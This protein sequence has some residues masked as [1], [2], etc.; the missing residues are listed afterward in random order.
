MD[1]HFRAFSFVDRISSI[2]AG[3][4]VAGHYVIPATLADFSNSLVSEAVGQL[5][6][7]GAMSAVDFTHRPVAGLAGRVE[8]LSEVRPGQTLDLTAE[9]ESVD[10]DA[11]AYAGSASVEGRPVVRLQHC[12]GPMMP[13]EGF[14]NPLLVRQ[15]FALLM[16]EEAAPGTFTGVPDIDLGSTTMTSESTLQATLQV[17]THADFFADHF[18]K[19]PVFPGT[20]LTHANLRLAAALMESIAPSTTSAQWIPKVIFDVK[21]R[22]FIPPGETLELEA[23][24]KEATSN[25]ATV[26]M[27]I[28]RAGKR[29]GSC[30]VELALEEAQ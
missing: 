5:A 13:L 26:G 1:L 17:P 2:Q 11:V 16:A 12:V 21:L 4:Q 20:L 22:S 19:Q 23:R 10:E 29:A 18:P 24:M 25:T 27:Q 30:R 7:W 14:D 8:L 6:A 3:P 9:I 28:R 15:R